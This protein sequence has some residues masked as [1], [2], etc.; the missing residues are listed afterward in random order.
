MIR[1]G[2][3]GGKLRQLEKAIKPVTGGAQT[4]FSVSRES[5]QMG[6]QNHKIVGRR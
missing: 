3:S 4:R 5:R 2:V 6:Q 1:T